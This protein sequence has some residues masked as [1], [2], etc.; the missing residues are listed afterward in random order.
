MQTRLLLFFIALA[1]APFLW[2]PVSSAQI[3]IIPGS[4]VRGAD[5]F[6]KR[7][8]VQCHAFNG[9]GG[10]VAP[11]LAQQTGRSHPPM[12]LAS[13][14]WNHGPQMWRAQDSRQLRATLDSM[15]TADLFAYFYSVSYFSAP[16]NAAKGAA[17]F[18]E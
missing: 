18:E 11:V 1:L 16:G 6:Q 7:G 5:L 17:L 12:Q 10:K 15:E 4:S 14:L 13:E 8:C 3:D 9:I 2:P